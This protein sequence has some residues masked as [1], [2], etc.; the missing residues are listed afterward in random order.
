MTTLLDQ[1]VAMQP[2]AAYGTAAVDKLVGYESTVDGWARNVIHIEGGG[3]K[4]GRAGIQSNRRV[5]VDRGA[6]GRIETSVLTRG[7]NT[8]LQH[9]LGEYTAPAGVDGENG[10]FRSIA[11]ATA[12]GPDG[13]Y[14]VV[15][16]RADTQGAMRYFQ[17]VGAVPTGFALSIAQGEALTLGVDYDAQKEELLSSAP[18][19]PT[20]TDAGTTEL[21][22]YEGA[23]VAV[24]GSKVSY[25]R[26][27]SLT[28]DL[29]LDKERFFLQGS[30]DKKQPLR[31]GVPTYT[32]TMSGEF[33]DDAEYERFVDGS[34][35]SVELTVNGRRNITG[36][37]QTP[38]F[39]VTLP[40]V[41]YNGST[42]VS[43]LASLS[44]I[45][46]P[47]VALSNASD[48]ICTIEYISADDS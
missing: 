39:K 37:T 15:V 46:I 20:Y 33:F 47:F 13:S 1:Y 16:A 25:F 40:A 38:K 36:T 14:T 48:K 35:V 8:R 45:E 31:N 7:E 6:T 29:M 43:D 4:P 19:A 24:G 42:P 21:F 23:E 10:A 44:S 32:G 9:L 27:F 2:E 12:Q 30:A 11:D 22:V 5:K 41:Q 3:R 17:Y 26:S 18:D 28:A 34:I